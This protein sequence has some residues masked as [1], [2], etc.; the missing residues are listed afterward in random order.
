MVQLLDYRDFQ[1]KDKSTV[2]GGFSWSDFK[3]LM[4]K[5]RKI[6][7]HVFKVGEW[8]T[9]EDI[10]GVHSFSPQQ[11]VFVLLIIISKLKST[12]IRAFLGG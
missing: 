4:V 5:F 11:N 2:S 3:N 6:K 10:H 1:V 9:V 7:L 12:S 8:V